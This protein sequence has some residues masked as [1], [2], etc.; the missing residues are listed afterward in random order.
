MDFLNITVAGITEAWEKLAA[1][2][3]ESEG[4][5]FDAWKNFMD[6]ADSR[7]RKVAERKAELIHENQDIGQQLEDLGNLYT[8]CMLEENEEKA[9][10]IKQQM[11][12]LASKRAANGVLITSVEK[13]PYSEILL[14]AADAAFDD[15]GSA[16]T[17]LYQRRSEI[18]EAVDS[19]ISTLEKL[20]RE[21]YYNSGSTLPADYNM[22][23]QRRYN[24]QSE[25]PNEGSKGFGFKA[26]R[27][28][29]NDADADGSVNR[30]NGFYPFHRSTGDPD[31]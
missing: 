17:E 1:S 31:F 15:Y 3:K 26:T 8:E 7:D 4:K 28:V 19:M 2:I 9:A 21:I 10:A 29:I 20:Q 5:F 22:R 23:M 27:A 13:P 11:A 16:S 12:E 25:F 18:Q 14:K 24:G 6:D 30:D